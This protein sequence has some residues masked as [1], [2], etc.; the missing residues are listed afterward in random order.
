MNI[1]IYQ[2]VNI[3]FKQTYKYIN[4]YI[5]IFINYP[6]INWNIISSLVAIYSTVGERVPICRRKMLLKI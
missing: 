2:I 6:L 5:Y 1:Y 4:I 3:I